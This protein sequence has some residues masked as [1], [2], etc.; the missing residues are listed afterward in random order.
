MTWEGWYRDTCTDTLIEIRNHLQAYLDGPHHPD[1]PAVHVRPE[2]EEVVARIN[3]ELRRRNPIGYWY[4]DR[5]NE[6]P[7]SYMGD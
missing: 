7:T 3:D 4:S 2:Y 1:A 6:D 5:Y